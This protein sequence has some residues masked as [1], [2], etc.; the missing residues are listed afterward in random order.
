MLISQWYLLQTTTNGAESMWFYK[1]GGLS[2][3]N[4]FIILKSCILCG[5][6]SILTGIQKLV[7]ILRMPSIVCNFLLY[8]IP[9]I[10]QMLIESGLYIYIRDQPSICLNKKVRVY[11]KFRPLA[12]QRS[13]NLAKIP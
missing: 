11:L 6:H 7:L 4:C 8:F 2:L 12:V 9:Y 10:C 13:V 1:I 5:N 3:Q